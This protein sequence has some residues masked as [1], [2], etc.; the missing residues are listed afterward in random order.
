MILTKGK[1]VKISARIPPSLYLVSKFVC[2]VQGVSMEKKIIALLRKDM[3]AALK[4]K[5]VLDAGSEVELLLKYSAE[6]ESSEGELSD[7][8]F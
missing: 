4:K 6:D 2:R 3:K 5:Y 8:E 7:D 1:N